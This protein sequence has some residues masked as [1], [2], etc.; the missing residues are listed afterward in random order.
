MTLQ[1]AVSTIESVNGNRRIKRFV[2]RLVNERFHIALYMPDTAGQTANQLWH[3]FEEGLVGFRG[4]I[5]SFSLYSDEPNYESYL[6]INEAEFGTENV[7]ERNYATPT[8]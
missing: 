8:T 7:I 5:V 2:V 4:V 6:A 3:F 1:E